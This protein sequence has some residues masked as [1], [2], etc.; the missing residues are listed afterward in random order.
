MSSYKLTM[1]R[2]T[3]EN[4]ISQRLETHSTLIFCNICHCSSATIFYWEWDIAFQ[5]AMLPAFPPYS[6]YRTDAPI[7]YSRDFCKTRSRSWAN[8]SNSQLGPSLSTTVTVVLRLNRKPVFY[9]R[10]RHGNRRGQP[11]HERCVPPPESKQIWSLRRFSCP[12]R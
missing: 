12:A 5:P 6:S 11:Y 8:S 4:S 10:P 3:G 2:L 9:G 7:T 1:T